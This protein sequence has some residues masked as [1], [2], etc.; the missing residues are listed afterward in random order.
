MLNIKLKEKET[1]TERENILQ[2]SIFFFIT[3]IHWV[4]V[5]PLFYYLSG[6][7]VQISSTQNRKKKRGIF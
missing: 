6:Y 1:N 2:R 3:E 7:I 5:L 4:L